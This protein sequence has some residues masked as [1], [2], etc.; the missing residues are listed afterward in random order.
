SKHIEYKGLGTEKVA[1]DLR[2]ILPELRIARLDYDTTRNKNAHQ[3]IITD[4]EEKK[5]DVLVGTQMVAKGL[6][7]DNVTLIGIINADTILQ[8]PD[9]RAYERSFQLLSQ[10]AGRA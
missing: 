9:F 3:H 2:N 5:L 1:D 10:V 8:F 7:F 6:D 4:F